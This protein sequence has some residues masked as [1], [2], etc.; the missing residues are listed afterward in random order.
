MMGD[1][2]KDHSLD[3]LLQRLSD[4]REDI[5]I[6]REEILRRG[7]SI[8]QGVIDGSFAT[9][10]FENEELFRP[11]YLGLMNAVYNFDLSHGKGFREYAEN[12][13]KGEIRQHIRD[14]VQRAPIPR[15]MKDLNRQIEATEA[16]LLRETGRLPSL[17]ELA[18]AVNITEEGLAEVFKARETLSY[19]SLN[20]EQRENDPVFEIDITKIHSKQSVAFPVEYRIRLASALEKLADLQQYLFHSLFRPSE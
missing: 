15:W 18:E 8:I 12:L 20:A 9:S 2:L 11:G 17:S 13:V 16:R 3:E 5:E 14:Q 6:V 4:E 1:T 10:G 7:T 19:V